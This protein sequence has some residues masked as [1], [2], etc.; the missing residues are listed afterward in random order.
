[1]NPSSI[2]LRW[3]A[4]CCV[5]LTPP[6]MGAAEQ[7][8]LVFIIADDL[9]WADVEFHGGNTPTP[10]LNRLLA[11]GVELKQHYVA[12][13]CSP[14][15]AGFLTGR[16]WSRFG[17]TTPI[18]NCGLPFET[19]TVAKALSDAGYATAL[20]GKWHLGSK[21]E[22][23]P[24]HFGFDHSYGSLAGGVA[25]YNHHYK[26]GPYSS[27]WHRNQ[28]LFTEKG[29][30]TDL[31]TDEAVQWIK[32]QTTPTA[33]RPFFLY[34]PYTAVH[35]PI[36]EPEEWM[37]QVPT[38]I[39]GE[40]PRQYAAC[41]M[42]FDAAVGRIVEAIDQAGQRDNTLIVFTS[43]N[44]GSTAENNDTKYP[45]DQCSNGKLTGNNLPLRGKKGTLYEGGIRVPTIARWP[46]N[47]TPG[48]T[49]DFP[50]C[51]VDWMPTFC[52]LANAKTDADTLKWDGLN[53]WPSLTGAAP[54]AKR[55]FH[56]AGTRN[57]WAL[58]SAD[59]KL[60]LTQPKRGDS[61]IELFNLGTD[62]NETTN[63]AEAKPKIVDELRATMEQQRQRDLTSR[64]GL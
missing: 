10:N 44:G 58:R 48:T 50:A 52:A 20:I 45:D 22:W 16:Y 62:P 55:S 1:M 31:L 42:H 21:P 27:T 37:N 39:K 59:W 4:L 61:K 60:I 2:L 32:N 17:I 49:F 63:L 12:P 18:N 24:N 6:S 29:H 5:L 25:P 40:V 56:I 53:L 34:L 51:V 7:P 33:T 41:I 57:S 43:D 38:E 23:G 64:G 8:N 35:L 36:R 47:L 3:A 14:T 26:K 28:K 9:G 19:V 30:V 11:E 15:R 13:V 54:P 46:G